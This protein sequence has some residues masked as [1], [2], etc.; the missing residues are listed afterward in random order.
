MDRFIGQGV[1]GIIVIAPETTAVAALG[2]LATDIPLVAVGAGRLPLPSVTIDN[3]A[4]AA[5]RPGTCSTSVTRQ[6][7]KSA[8]P[9]TW[10][11]A[12]QR[13][14][15]W[16]QTLRAAGAGNPNC[17]AVTGRRD[18]ATNWS[19]AGCDAGGDRS[20]LRQ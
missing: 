11:D 2:G 12:Q 18:R 10:L 16:R 13:V 17:S 15:G 14:D 3:V 6:S 5:E 19:S 7:T 1:E 20:A 4:G 9:A 8:G